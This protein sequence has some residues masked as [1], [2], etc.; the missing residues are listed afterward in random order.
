VHVL[1]GPF[2][3][4]G[5]EPGDLLIVDIL[6]IDAC[7]QEDSGPYSGMGWGYTG[8]F[9][10]KNGGGFLTERFPDAYKV[11]WD[12]K[13]DVAT[14]RH[15]PEV[16]YVG[17]HH[18]GL[19]GTAPSAELLAK[20]TKRET[21]LI[22]TDPHRVPPLALPPLPDSAILG[23]LKGAE[24]DR[25]AREAARTAPPRENG[26]NQ[27]IKNLT[28][29]SRVF[30]PV[31]VPGAKLSFGDLHFSQGDG[32]ITFCGAIEMGGFMDLHV[33][34]IKGGMAAY[35]ISENAIFMPGLRDPQYSEWIAFSGVSVDLAGKQ[36]YLDSQLS[37]ARACH[38]AIDYLMKFGY[39]DIQAYMILGSA[40]VEGR[41]SGV[42]D[43]PNSCATIYIPRA[44]F[45]FDVRPSK[46]GKPHQVKQGVQVPK[47][48]N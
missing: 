40:P 45:D 5:A 9:A 37:Y 32:E 10:T 19:M 30:Y 27:D 1:T 42:V 36:H 44:I 35:G 26:G 12:F 18:P 8:V 24:F 6:E 13:G 38:H 15:I 39:S 20:W 46:S 29:G 16:S 17:I 21:D 25:V 41:F 34:L 31:F 3:V 2:H 33:D 47:S 4:E 28:A 11:I 7:D 23:S 43:I 48:A 14:S 22:A